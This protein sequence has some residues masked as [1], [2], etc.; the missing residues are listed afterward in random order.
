MDEQI[1]AS[2]AKVL[3]D[4]NLLIVFS[5]GETMSV[6]AEA[7]ASLRDRNVCFTDAVEIEKQKAL[8]SLLD[9]WKKQVASK[10]EIFF[11]DDE[12]YYSPEDFFVYDGFFPDYFSQKRKVLFI[13]RE[14]RWISKYDFRN[15]TKDFFLQNNVNASGFWRTILRLLYGIQHEG[16]LSYA[17]IPCADEI[18]KEMAQSDNFGLAVM[19]LSKYS[20]DSEDGAT[21]N[22][23]M[24]NRFLEDSELEKRNFFQEE[25]ALL[26]PDI[27]ITGNLWECGI[28]D[29]YMELCFPEK[30]F[31]NWK[32]YKHGTAE[33]GEY[34]LNGKSVPFINTY[35]FSARKAFKDDFYTPVMKI[36]FP[37]K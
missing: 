22:R 13:A 23:A 2:S 8:L 6:D 18:A 21:A 28:K 29:E 4:G 1:R 32:S 36:L 16:K 15:T 24:M 11:P 14:T 10:P 37:K 3:E 7:V 30:N 12:F 31:K 35:H 20:N 17:D 9:S 26:D 33:Y 34:D 19:Q 25:L 5:N 27:I